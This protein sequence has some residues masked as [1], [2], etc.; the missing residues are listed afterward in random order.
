MQNLVFETKV[1]SQLIDLKKIKDRIFV[2]TT[3]C[4]MRPPRQARPHNTSEE[5]HAIGLELLYS[6]T[7][8]IFR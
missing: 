6:E 1:N 3:Y 5:V 7:H 2:G 4:I 8:S